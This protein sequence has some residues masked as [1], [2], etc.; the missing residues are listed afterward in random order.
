D[1]TKVNN[2]LKQ[3][4][5]QKGAT[6]PAQ[7]SHHENSTLQH[8][9]NVSGPDFDKAYAKGMV[10]DHKKDVKE[11]ENAAKDLKD[12]DVRALAQKILQQHLGMA[13][14]LETGAKPEK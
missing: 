1:H 11:F 10:K 9:Q 2:E 13:E 8:L 12:P 4:A 6:L 7:M 5:G 14:I 3:I